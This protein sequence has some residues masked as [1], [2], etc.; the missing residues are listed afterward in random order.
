MYLQACGYAR[1]LLPLLGGATWHDEEVY[2]PPPLPSP[3][4]LQGALDVWGR[5]A[6]I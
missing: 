1:S 2:G 6:A 4:T 5:V 3:Q